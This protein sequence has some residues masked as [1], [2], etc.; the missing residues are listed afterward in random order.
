MTV[1]DI[2]GINELTIDGIAAMVDRDWDDVNYAAR[3][4]LDAMY[5]LGTL[6]DNYGL[7]SG[8]SVVSYFLANAGTWRGPVARAV[9]AELRRRLLAGR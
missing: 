1:R 7:D 9:K 2:D 4:Y 8:R 5:S 3:P 6:D